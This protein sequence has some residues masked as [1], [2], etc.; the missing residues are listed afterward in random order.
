MAHMT[1]SDL[2]RLPLL[3]WVLWWGV[4]LHMFGNIA[5]ASGHVV[6]WKLGLITSTPGMLMIT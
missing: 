5:T 2:K 6:G 1:S 4:V 3:L